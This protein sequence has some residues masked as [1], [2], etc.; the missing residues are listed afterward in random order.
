MYFQQIILLRKC[1]STGLRHLQAFIIM[2]GENIKLLSVC[3]ITQ[4]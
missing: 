1:V 3:S 2:K 4:F